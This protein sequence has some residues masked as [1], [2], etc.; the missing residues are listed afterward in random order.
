MGGCRPIAKCWLDLRSPSKD[1]RHDCSRSVLEFLVR[2]FPERDDGG[3]RTRCRRFHFSACQPKAACESLSKQ[4]AMRPAESPMAVGC[5]PATFESGCV[6]VR[7]VSRLFGARALSNVSGCHGIER[8]SSLGG[9]WYLSWSAGVASA[10]GK[11]PNSPS[12][13]RRRGVES[14]SRGFLFVF[15][16]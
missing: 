13:Q 3:G 1:N 4:G 11:R 9:L 7:A 12:R 16:R 10:I 8:R 2:D 14:F 5:H 15:L 6:R